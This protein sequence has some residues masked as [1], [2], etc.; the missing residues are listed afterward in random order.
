MAKILQIYLIKELFRTFL[1]ALLCFELLVLL[2][3]SVQ[4]IHKGLDVPSLAYIVP[5]LALYALPHA[6]PSSLLAATVMTYG[7]LS[8]DNEIAA[9]KTAGLHLHNI[10]SP[11]VII[12]IFF[13][14]LSL[15]LYAEVLPM[16]YFKVR[17][18]QEK[19]VKQVLAKHFIAAKRKI[20]FHPYQIY[21]SNVEGGIYK[22]IAVFEYAE[23]YIVSVLLSEEGEIEINEAG[24][25]ASLT[26][27]RGEFIRPNIKNN[28]DVP[29][30]GSFEEATFVI[31]IRQK[32]HNT[33]LKY[34]SL[35]NLL[36]QKK[37]VD[38]ELV[39]SKEKFEDPRKT[40][41]AAIKNIS[42]TD[43]KLDM[44]KRRLE[45]ERLEIKDSETN[46]LRQAGVIKRADQDIDIFENYIRVA[47]NNIEKLMRSER[48]AE[49]NNNQEFVESSVDT[50]DSEDEYSKKILLIKE[51]IE[52]EKRRVQDA[53]EKILIAEKTRLDESR[54]IAKAKSNIEEVG[55]VKAQLE[56]EHSTLSERIESSKRQKLKRALTM[57]IHKRL[58]LS[59]SC[60]TFI[61]IGI[62]LGIMTR[63]S[64]ML[65]SLGI[66]FV[67]VLFFYYPLVA[68]GL[69]L[70]DSYMFPIIPS[71]WGA[72]GFTVVL[73]LVLFWRV[74]KR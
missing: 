8:A 69:I 5:Y 29:K 44:I 60:L 51:I 59:F 33:A 38:M 67:V 53:R 7:R 9:V 32:V 68:T 37:T 47:N 22:D 57:N 42:K 55:L 71:L 39:N 26:L 28:T 24:D 46:I 18:L 54:N 31:P 74:L 30:M 11:I 3:F 72:N 4:L 12:G 45:K 21:V 56:K 2:G 27:R 65:V 63:S 66:S 48:S 16:S 50:H 62:P 10:I 25:L 14:I 1:P 40:L 34:A 20:N 13:S 49:N 64:S 6:L 36:T 52:R 19:A 41:K 17:S 15:Y 58:S 23:D 43:N 73:G 35:T 70:A 61:L